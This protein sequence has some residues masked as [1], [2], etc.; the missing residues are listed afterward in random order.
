MCLLPYFVKVIT[1]LEGRV[2]SRNAL[3]GDSSQPCTQNE[4]ATKGRQSDRQIQLQNDDCFTRPMTRAT[5]EMSRV[6]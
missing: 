1:K 6:S 2:P 4:K 3:L 5:V